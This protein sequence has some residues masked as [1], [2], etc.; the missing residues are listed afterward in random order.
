V[1]AVIRRLSVDELPQ[2][3]NVLCGEMSLVGPPSH[4][5]GTSAEGQPVQALAAHYG[6]RHLVRPGITGLAQVR[7]LRV[8]MH[9]TQHVLDRLQAD[10]EY[11][12][13]QSL[14]LNFRITVMTL[15][16]EIRSNRAF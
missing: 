5:P 16:R 8:G 9:T 4:G 15:V 6:R 12:R 3:I 1:G 11:I 2:L 7:R 10:L 13:R 14:R